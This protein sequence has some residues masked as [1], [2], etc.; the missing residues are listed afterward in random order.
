MAPM[1][2]T[3]KMDNLVVMDKMG[4]SLVLVDNGNWWVGNTDLGVKAQGNPGTNGQNGQPGRDGQ[5]GE[6]PRI[7]D[8]GNWWIGNQD[9]GKP[10]SW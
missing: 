9:T 10:G 6:T 4:K 5:N 1:D 2:K 8:N 7:G 3:D